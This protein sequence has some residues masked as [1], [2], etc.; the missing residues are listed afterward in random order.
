MISHLSVFS[1]RAYFRSLRFYHIMPE[2]ENQYDVFFHFSD[3]NKY[4]Y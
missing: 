4:E 1:Q 3:I 2:R